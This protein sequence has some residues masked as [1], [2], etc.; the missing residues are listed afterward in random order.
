MADEQGPSRPSGDHDSTLWLV[1][2]AALIV[3]GIF[4]GARSL[5]I[6]P[7]PVTIIFEGLIEARTGIG[8]LLL[9]VALIVWARSDR[10]F[11]APA[12]GTKLFRSRDNKWVA[13]VLGGLSE[14]F[15]VDVTLLRLAF[16]ALVFFFDV[17][18]LVVAYIVMAVVV[19]QEPEVPGSVPPA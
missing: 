14:Y 2:G 17:G 12:R 15:D 5:G 6:V 19:P 16:L 7:W 10:R 3:A 13:G 11:T 18:V 8:I 9:G 4:F 1:L